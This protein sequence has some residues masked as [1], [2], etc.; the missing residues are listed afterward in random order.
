MENG[1]HEKA[2]LIFGNLITLDRQNFCF[3]L[4][5]LEFEIPF[6]DNETNEALSSSISISE[7]LI[8]KNQKKK[9]KKKVY[10]FFDIFVYYLIGFFFFLIRALRKKR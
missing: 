3:S 4:D 7:M 2:I 5:L 10:L 8:K 9:R 6:E 1:E